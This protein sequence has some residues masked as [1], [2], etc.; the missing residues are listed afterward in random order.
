[1]LE[2]FLPMLIAFFIVIALVPICIPLLRRL[3]MGNTEREYIKEH[4]AKN[5]TPSMGGIM[6]LIAFAVV[7]LLFG[8]NVPHIYPIVI[9][10]VG[11][12]IL[13]F[14]D[15]LLKA[16][17]RSSDGLKAWQ[18]MLGQILLTTGF[19]VYMVKFSDVSLELRIPATG[20]FVD[21][22]W[23]SVPLLFLAVLGTV[24]GANFTDGLDGLAT[25]VTLAIAGFWGLVAIHLSSDITPAIA[26]MIG[27]LFGFLM[28]NVHPAKIFMGDTGSLALGAFVVSVAYTLQ[29]PI[30]I[31]VVALIYLAEVLS[32]IL[33]VGYFKMTGG[34]RIF[35]MAPI[36]HH[37]ELGGWSEVKVVAVFTTVT[38]FLCTFAYFLV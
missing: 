16:L 24:N 12:G 32:V 25:S 2:V 1:M 36:H 20:A 17:K 5:G 13:G 35:R 34:K 23:L 26:A 33:Q 28:F 38:I 22:S 31:I 14:V 15:D 6:I 27:A 18:K 7:S 21:I 30:F 11:F 3:K 8:R 29:M 4:K 37:Y 9:L 10:T 19:A